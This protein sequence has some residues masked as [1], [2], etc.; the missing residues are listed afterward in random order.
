MIARRTRP[1]SVESGRT[2]HVACRASWPRGRPPARAQPVRPPAL[3][4]PRRNLCDASSL[5]FVE[6]L[7]SIG[8]LRHVA[9]SQHATA[10]STGTSTGIGLEN[11]DRRCLAEAQARQMAVNGR[12]FDILDRGKPLIGV[13]SLHFNRRAALESISGQSALET[14]ASAGTTLNRV[15]AAKNQQHLPS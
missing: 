5:L 14:T 8:S 13:G 3:R 7:Y 6:S 1:W 11:V 10:L 2:R 12:P 4:S 9:Y 15:P